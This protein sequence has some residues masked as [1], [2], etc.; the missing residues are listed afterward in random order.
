MRRSVELSH[1]HF[2]I[3]YRQTLRCRH[4]AISIKR[5]CNHLEMSQRLHNRRF[6]FRRTLRLFGIFLLRQVIILPD[7]QTTFPLDL[8]NIQGRYL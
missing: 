7:L 1:M 6:L 5:L 2:I 3:K 8:R 4:F